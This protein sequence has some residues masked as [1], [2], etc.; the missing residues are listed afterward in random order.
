[1]VNILYLHTH[2]SVRF[3]QPYGYAIPTP[4]LMTLAQEGVLFRSCFCA[5]PSCSA[6]R[7]AM[8]TGMNPHSSGMIG[9]AHRGF[10]LKDPRQHLA[11]Y[12]AEHGF[13][14]VLCGV[15]HEITHGHESELGYEQFLQGKITPDEDLPFTAEREQARRAAQDF[16]NASVAANYLLQPKTRPFFLS[17]G[18][19][20]THFD[21]PKP[22]LNINPAYIQPPPTLPDNP[23]TR[24]DMAGYLTLARQADQCF[25]LVLSALH[26]S[27]LDEDTLVLYTTDHGV[28]FPMMKCT[29]YDYG[30][31]VALI[32]RFP[33]GC[34]GGSVVDALVSH[35]DIFPTICDLTNLPRP[36]WLE[37]KSLI[38][39]IEE[40][41]DILDDEI[42][43][44][45]TYH[46]A[47]EPMRCVRTERYKYIRYFDKYEETIKTNIDW[48]PSKDF[49][50]EHGLRERAH[51]P[52]E[53][54]FDLYFD[55]TERVN[56]VEDP[57][58]GEI[59][60]DLSDRL[61]GWMEATDD[62]LLHGYISKPSGT[63]ANRKNGIHPFEMEWEA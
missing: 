60:Q 55:P 50:L 51:D 2:D 6:S 56:L 18:L 27:G 39:L 62:P 21:L 34:H 63:V 8:L 38:P 59:R 15:Q 32:L 40:E 19:Q 48:S 58:Y 61:K 45:V 57:H 12:L 52:P 26:Q 41:V 43:A 44:E 17:L 25:G 35:L 28:A 20:S 13:E 10:S 22:A 7:S 31:G 47:Y 11:H 4:H 54:L 46:A 14:T 23:I 16:E 53:M 49:L 33:G 1:M 42:F 29:L 24:R 5:A 9:L 3:L 37:G 30:I 36:K